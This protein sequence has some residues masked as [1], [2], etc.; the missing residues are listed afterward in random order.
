M[1]INT[2][3]HSPLAFPFKVESQTEDNPLTVESK[4]V[5]ARIQEEDWKVRIDLGNEK[6]KIRNISENVSPCSQKQ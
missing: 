1:C 2:H 5:K 3:T 6:G 4:W